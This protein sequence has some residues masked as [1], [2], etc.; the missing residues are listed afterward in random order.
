[1]QLWPLQRQFEKAYLSKYKKQHL[2]WDH[3]ASS[4]VLETRY[5]SPAQLIATVAQ[6]SV[7]LLYND[8]ST[9]TYAEIKAKTGMQSMELTRILQ[10]L[11]TNRRGSSQS[12][13]SAEND[14]NSLLHKNPR[15]TPIRPSDEFN[16]NPNYTRTASRINIM[17]A[18]DT[19]TKEDVQRKIVNED[20]KQ[21]R[22]NQVSL[23]QLSFPGSFVHA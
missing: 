9:Y 19:D 2:I 8:R 4:C 15:D 7:L 12:T 22:R 11:C 10:S 17:N 23:K 18:I 14:Q 21:S 16:Y 1:M 3:P 5:R 13:T 20:V 6:T